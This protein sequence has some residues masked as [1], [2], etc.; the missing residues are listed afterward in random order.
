VFSTDDTQYIIHRDT[1]YT[2]QICFRNSLFFDEWS[3]YSDNI[4][5]IRD[6][7]IITGDF[8]FHLDNN[9]DAEARRFGS[10]LDSH[11]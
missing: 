8:N 10:M 7:V 1:N 3:K 2:K 11:G 9:S 6:G 5:M 4:V